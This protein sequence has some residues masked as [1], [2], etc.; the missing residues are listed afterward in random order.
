MFMTINDLPNFGASKALAD[1]K[2]AREDLKK[3]LQQ[4]QLAKKLLAQ[5]LE[6]MRLFRIDAHEY[7]RQQS[8]PK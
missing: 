2:L 8:S 4:C 1:L 5:K 6:E 3:T 7:L